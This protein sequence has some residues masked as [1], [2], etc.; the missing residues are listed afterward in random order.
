VYELFALRFQLTLHSINDFDEWIDSK[1]NEKYRFNIST[2]S[3]IDT[4]LKKR[5]GIETYT[6]GVSCNPAAI[7]FTSFHSCF[8]IAQMV[9]KFF[10]FVC[11]MS[12]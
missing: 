2:L 12:V 6:K 11:L 3:L 1:N 9:S 5:I 4:I 7:N 8:N 10:Q